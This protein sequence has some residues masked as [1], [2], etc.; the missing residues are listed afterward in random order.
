MPGKSGRSGA[1]AGV[2]VLAG[3][4]CAVLSRCLADWRRQCPAGMRT[5]D[6]LEVEAAVNAVR[7]AAAGWYAQLERERLLRAGSGEGQGKSEAAD[8]DEWIPT[9]EAAA[10]LGLSTRR[11]RQLASERRLE[12]AKVDG[13]T[14]FRRSQVLGLRRTTAS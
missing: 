2:A 6:L 5:E 3:L 12:S 8:S 7:E 14:Y 10:I 1:V 11:V 9:R 13:R 4:P